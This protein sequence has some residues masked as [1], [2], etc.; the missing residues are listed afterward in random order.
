MIKSLLLLLLLIPS[1]AWSRD[2]SSGCGPAWYILPENSLV[3]SALRAVTNGI[4]WPIST[5]GMTVGSSNCTQH[6]L[7]LKEKE[8]LY[9]A[10]QNYH[11]LWREGS[12]G[13]GEFI[14]AYYSTLGCQ[15]NKEQHFSSKIQQHYQTLFSEHQSPEGFLLETYK[16]ILLDPE[17]TQYCSLG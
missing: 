16:I 2:S 10:T 1:F 3:S 15:A 13:G 11:E 5:I 8:S 4:T 9:F 14:A 7:V 6:K 12:K 17:L